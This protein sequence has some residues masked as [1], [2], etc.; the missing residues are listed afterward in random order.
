MSE[1]QIIETP[2][3]ESPVELTPEQGFEQAIAMGTTVQPEVPKVEEPVVAIPE[4]EVTTKPEIVET[5]IPEVTADTRDA[6]IAELR[7]TISALTAEVPLKKA[8]GEKPVTPA[9]VTIARFCGEEDYDTVLSDPNLFA[10]HLDK[11][12]SEAMAKTRT[13]LVRDV[14]ELTSRQIAEQ[15]QGLKNFQDF[16]NRNEDLKDYVPLIIHQTEKLATER[17]EVCHTPE[18]ESALVERCRNVLKM[19]PQQKTTPA[20]KP[21]A[22]HFA[23]NTGRR[24]NVETGDPNDPVVAFALQHAA[25]RR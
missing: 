6:T 10:E 19:A 20:K 24:H 25:G 8:T 12:V 17:P 1:V 13:A 5:V 18:F 21:V 7:A 15:Q 16:L 9:E 2:V 3:V 23:G 22:G 4:P 14:A 11:Y